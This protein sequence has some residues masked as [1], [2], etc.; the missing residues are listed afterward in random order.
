VNISYVVGHERAN[1][2]SF[3]SI[4]AILWVLIIFW[5]EYMKRST[6][7]KGGGLRQTICA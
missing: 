2:L 3:Q 7:Y 1:I 4:V 5:C 6:V